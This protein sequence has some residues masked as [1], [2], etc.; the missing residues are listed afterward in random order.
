MA[1][2]NVFVKK[3]KRLAHGY[4]TTTAKTISHG[5]SKDVSVA[6][7]KRLVHGYETVK[8]DNPDKYYKSG[9]RITEIETEIKDYE[10][11]VSDHS[12]PQ[13]EKDFAKG[14]IEDLKKE[15]EKLKAEPK[16]E[17]KIAPK[18]EKKAAKPKVEIVKKAPKP[19]KNSEL[20]SCDELE[21]R[22]RKRKEAA[23]KAAKKHKTTSISERIGGDVAQAVKKIVDNIPAADIKANPKSYIAK[24]EKIE[25]ATKG[26]VDSLKSLLGDDFS[27]S[28]ILEPFE[29]MIG[30]FIKNVKAKYE[31]K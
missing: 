7:G 23:K 22:W 13:D 24:F 8:G 6:T 29:N 1:H 16:A 25:T 10:A 17:K 19:K 3:G 11:L 18:K 2:K 30:E 14:E 26:F 27:R 15:L 4:K 31:T 5:E 21:A 9:G 12:V 28:E 20:P